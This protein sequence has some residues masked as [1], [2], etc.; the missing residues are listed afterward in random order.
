MSE[1]K[2]MLGDCLEVMRG[3]PDESVDMVVTDPPYGMNYLSNHGTKHKKIKNDD[4]VDPS[5]LP[6]CMRL[7]KQGGGLISFTNWANSCEW[8]YWIEYYGF[9]VKSQVI[10]NRL[11]HGMGDLK[12][13]FAPMHD[14]VW[15]T[16]KGRRIFTNGRPK[17]VIDVK[18]PSPSQDHGHPTCKPVELMEKLIYS[19]DDGS[20]GIILDPFMG[21]GST[22]VACRN[23]GR[24]FIG[25]ELDADYYKIAEERIREATN[26]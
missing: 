6:E 22:G 4:V 9:T 25:I 23:L 16:T 21:S 7:L 19:T 3:I 5:F 17:S 20:N 8:M 26:E 10:W 13:A 18:R 2:L 11:H 24:D 14:V 15:Y 1:A 12:G